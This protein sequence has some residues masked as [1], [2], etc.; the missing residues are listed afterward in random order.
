LLLWSIILP[1][2]VVT[3]IIPWQLDEVVI[4]LILDTV[5]HF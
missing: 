1:V 3:M 2:T 5:Q 4:P